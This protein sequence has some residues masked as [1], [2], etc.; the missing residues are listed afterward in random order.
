MTSETTPKVFMSYTRADDE[1][2]GG[3][4]TKLREKLEPAIRFHSGR[5]I[6][7]FQDVEGIHLGENIQQRIG[8]SLDT[9]MVLLPIITPSYFNSK[10]CRQEFIYFCGRECILG[11]NDLIIPIY[12]QSVSDLDAAMKYDSQPSDDPIINRIAAIKCFDWRQLQEHDMDDPEVRKS[13]K[14]IAQRI[15]QVIHEI[16]TVSQKEPRIGL[17][18]FPFEDNWKEH[19][20]L[21]DWTDHFKPTAP[22]PEVW[23]NQLLPQLTTLYNQLYPQ[24]PKRIQLYLNA[25]LS[26]AL[27]FGYVFRGLANMQITAIDQYDMCW[28]TGTCPANMRP[29]EETPEEVDADGTDLTI[30]ISVTQSTNGGVNQWLT[31]EQPSVFQ[32]L[33]FVLP[34]YPKITNTDQA[35]AIAC[36]IRERILDLR[37]NRIPRKTHVFGAMPA[38]LA[39]LIGWHLNT[40]EPIQCYEFVGGGYQPSCLLS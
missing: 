20:Y 18:T 22:P 28:Q 29:L 34:G 8:E 6:E 9:T 26:A 12:Y 37:Q 25:R 30:E 32:R 1:F 39:M 31:D 14:A 23:H 4:L 10:W 35:L 16:Q 17:F 2:L 33:K 21:L 5:S 13:L 24:R 19:P 36:Q 40:F 15:I 11:R 7:V 3:A 38:G 27:A